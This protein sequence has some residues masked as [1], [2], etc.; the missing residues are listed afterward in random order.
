MTSE[1]PGQRK[2]KRSTKATVKASSKPKKLKGLGDVIET[3]TKATGIK[4]LIGDCSG[5]EKRKEKL[6][7]LYPFYSDCKINAITAELYVAHREM[8]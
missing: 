4:S 6:N 1:K 5:C 2:S 7:Q 3:I 8:A